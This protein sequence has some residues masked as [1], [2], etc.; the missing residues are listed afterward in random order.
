MLAGEA[1]N[2]SVNRVGPVAFDRFTDGGDGTAVVRVHCVHRFQHRGHLAVIV[3][4]CQREDVPSVRGPLAHD[5]VAVEARGDYAANLAANQAIV[6]ARVVVGNHHAQTLAH[7]QR[8]RLR[9]ELLRV[10]FGEREFAFQRNHFRRGRRAHHI[11]E[12]RFARGRRNADARGP[13]VHVVGAVR[14][15]GVSRKRT[16]APVFRLRKQRIVFQSRIAQQRLQRAGAAPESQRVDRQHGN[17]RVNVITRIAGLL[18]LAVQRLS[19]DHP[20]RIARWNRMAGREHEFIAVR[21]FRPA[22]I[23]TESAVFRPDQ[24]GR[25]VIRCVGQRSAEMPGLRVISQQHQ[26]HAGHVS[27]VVE[28]RIVRQR[29]LLGGRRNH[30]S[31][32]CHRRSKKY[33]IRE[34]GDSW[35]HDC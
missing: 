2:F 18:I 3:A 1:G 34:A 35:S 20:Q 21:V 8:E 9:L 10:T 29:F 11:P 17:Q 33:N 6:D 25:N 12:R 28:Q 4:V 13:A 22:V 23:V 30:L 27:N 5:I 31:E 24:M 19:H 15:F 16:N 7:L 14:A 26:G 32:R